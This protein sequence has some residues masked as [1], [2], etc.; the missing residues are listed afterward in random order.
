MFSND[1]C[2]VVDLL[3]TVWAT[4]VE[5]C[6]PKISKFEKTNCPSNPEAIFSIHFCKRWHAQIVMSR[7][8]QDWASHFLN[9]NFRTS[10][11]PAP[12]GQ[13]FL[14]TVMIPPKK[15][16]SFFFWAWAVICKNN[17]AQKKKKTCG[18]L[19]FCRMMKLAK[20]SYCSRMI[21]LLL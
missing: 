19:I 13:Y 10:I 4:C 17:T 1:F 8:I 21:I 5:A 7:K 9:N 14:C 6:L 2:F 15:K 11:A 18:G 16:K 20:S 3:M 12:P